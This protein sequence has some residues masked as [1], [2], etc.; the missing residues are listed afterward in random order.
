[1]D[2]SD[3]LD[4]LVHHRD[5]ESQKDLLSLI[6]IQWGLYNILGIWA[7]LLVWNSLLFWVFWTPTGILLMMG[8]LRLKTQGLGRTLWDYRLLPPIWVAN[9]SALPLLIWVFPG[10][11]HLYPESWIYSLTSTWVSLALYATGVFTKRWP[12]ALGALAYV[13]AAPAYLLFPDQASWIFT[14]ANVL[15]LIVPGLVLR[16]DARS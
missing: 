13:V 16:Y 3:R 4:S 10:L 6:L 14:G 9:L 15:G 7:Y 8:I 1:M 5:T 12:V 11:L 2:P